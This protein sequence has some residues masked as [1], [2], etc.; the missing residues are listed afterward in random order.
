M[1][2]PFVPTT[3]LVA[4]AVIEWLYQGEGLVNTLWFEKT[5]DIAW[6]PGSLGALL[7]GIANWLSGEL[8]PLLSVEGAVT[9]LYASGQD[10]QTAPFF[11]LFPVDYIGSVGGEGYPAN[12]AVSVRFGTNFT[13]RSFRGRNFVGCLPPTALDGSVV[14]NTFKADLVSAYGLLPTTIAAALDA[15]HVVVSKMAGGQWRELAVATPVQS[16]AVRKLRVNTMR[17][18]VNG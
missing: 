4:K 14:D 9:R 15:Q 11:E 16:Y 5:D 2:A 1:P 12:D 7:G 3:D 18:R 17:N 10:S 13:G 6:T 8:L